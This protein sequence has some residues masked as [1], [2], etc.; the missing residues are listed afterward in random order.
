MKTYNV[1]V[2]DKKGENF[3]SIFQVKAANKREAKRLA[4]FNMRFVAHAKIEIAKAEGK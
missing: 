4:Q 1:S 2:N 3:I